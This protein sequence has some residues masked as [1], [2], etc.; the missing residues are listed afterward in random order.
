MHQCLEGIQ[1]S[2]MVQ[3]TGEGRSRNSDTNLS[4]AVHHITAHNLNI[5]CHTHPT[6]PTLIE[7]HR[8]KGVRG[9]AVG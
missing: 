8:K 1:L 7:E 4:T 2:S 9:G 5:Q 3:S 6:T